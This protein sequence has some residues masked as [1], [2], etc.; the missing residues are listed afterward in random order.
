MMHINSCWFAFI[1]VGIV[2]Q[3]TVSRRYRAHDHVVRCK[4]LL[5]NE[6]FEILHLS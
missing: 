1:L 3:V 2:I 6:Y 5:K 4:Y